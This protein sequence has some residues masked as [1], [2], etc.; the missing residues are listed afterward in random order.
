MKVIKIE[1]LCRGL[2]YPGLW[3]VGKLVVGKKAGRQKIHL[4]FLG[5][6]QTYRS[7]MSGTRYLVSRNRFHRNFPQ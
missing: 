5:S 4:E 6:H 7:S 1:T 3:K 2:E